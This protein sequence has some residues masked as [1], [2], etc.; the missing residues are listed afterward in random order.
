MSIKA[1]LLGLLLPGAVLAA[2]P[3]RITVHNALADCVSIETATPLA[4]RQALQVDVDLRMLQST[5]ACGCTSMRVAYRSEADGKT[6][7][8]Q[9]FTLRGDLH[10]RLTLGTRAQT[11]T[12]TEL[13]LHFSCAAE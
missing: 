7:R 9:R 2:E 1:A 6:L 5:A 3:P 13:N 8:H 12:L 10:K 11:R 4:A